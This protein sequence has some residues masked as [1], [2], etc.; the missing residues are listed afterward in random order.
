MAHFKGYKDII[1]AEFADP[2]VAYSTKGRAMVESNQIE[3]D[4]DII[5]NRTPAQKS[6]SFAP[7]VS[8]EVSNYRLLYILYLQCYGKQI[9]DKRLPPNTPIRRGSAPPQVNVNSAKRS[10]LKTSGMI[11]TDTENSI[12]IQSLEP[13]RR[14]ERFSKS[15]ISN[16]NALSSILE[17]P[18][19]D[20]D[21]S[22][23]LQGRNVNKQ[24][25]DG[26]QGETESSL[27][28]EPDDLLLEMT[29]KKAK[30]GPLTPKKKCPIPLKD[31]TTI[32]EDCPKKISPEKIPSKQ[33]VIKTPEKRLFSERLDKS[34]GQEKLLDKKNDEFGEETET[35]SRDTSR[36][37]VTIVEQSP[38]RPGQSLPNVNVTPKTA[39][40]DDETIEKRRSTSRRKKSLPRTPTPAVRRTRS[41]LS[42][43]FES[44]MEKIEE[45]TE[46]GI[47][48]N[49]V[50]SDEVIE[51]NTVLISEESLSPTELPC[52]LD[53]SDSQDEEEKIRAERKEDSLNM[54][55]DEIDTEATSDNLVED[56]LIEDME[57]EDQDH[58]SEQQ[59]N[60]LTKEQRNEVRSK[61]RS[62][63]SVTVE[64][65]KTPVASRMV[66]M[67]AIKGS[68]IHKPKAPVSEKQSKTP[69][70][71]WS[72]VITKGLDDKAFRN[73]EVNRGEKVASKLKM[74]K[75][76]RE[77]EI[78]VS[79][80]QD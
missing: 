61:R 7:E 67:R 53:L 32:L 46:E 64:T 73:G 11:A 65:N 68:N 41:T 38:E 25:P 48:N 50:Q 69:K 30:V 54:E 49:K 2:N 77:K 74:K 17:S 62:S 78:T 27:K 75:S 1:N 44:D 70:T 36:K 8:P 5:D 28:D 31:F 9:F 34:R 42:D 16:N 35:N 20:E 4:N 18:L 22:K 12:P 21:S 59:V 58:E 3:K 80:V 72:H 43:N 15:N 40:I 56:N 19:S 37:S 33:K 52:K 47:S 57:T 39:A 51:E 55:K 71:L 24:F 26:K 60:K 6:V 29:P 13:K 79:N 14:S 23:K 45:S 63:F 66:A 76:H 10:S